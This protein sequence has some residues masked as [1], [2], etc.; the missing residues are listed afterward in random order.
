ML[1]PIEGELPEEESGD[2]A[3][4]SELR[5]SLACMEE[6]YGKSRDD[7]AARAAI[8]A[9]AVTRFVVENKHIVFDTI[10]N[11]PEES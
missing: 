2:Q 7:D 5:R 3:F 9:R 8:L 10:D 11:E 4:A 1:R 6:S